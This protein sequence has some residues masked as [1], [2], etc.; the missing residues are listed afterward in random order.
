MM[1][2]Q[3]KKKT[4]KQTKNNNKNPVASYRQ[5]L[6]QNDDKHYPEWTL[7]EKCGATKFVY[8]TKIGIIKTSQLVKWVNRF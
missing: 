8:T 7:H 3:P 4:K 1:K 2:K 5:S 6:M